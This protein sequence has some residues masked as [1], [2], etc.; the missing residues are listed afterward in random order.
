MAYPDSPV[1]SLLV[2]IPAFVVV[3][4]FVSLGAFKIGALVGL[5]IVAEMIPIN[6]SWRIVQAIKMNT[7]RPRPLR[8]KE[9]TG[10]NNMDIQNP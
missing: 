3:E 5:Q 9:D 6:V 10:R 4:H 8:Y 2:H 7:S 1:S